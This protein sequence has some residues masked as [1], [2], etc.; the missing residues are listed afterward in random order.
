MLGGNP[1]YRR[2]QL[3]TEGRLETFDELGHFV[4]ARPGFWMAFEEG[5]SLLDG[6]RDEV[7]LLF[8]CIASVG[9]SRY[10]MSLDGPQYVPQLLGIWSVAPPSGSLS[11]SGSPATSMK[12]MSLWTSSSVTN[13]SSRPPR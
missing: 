5:A 1:M 11:F 4:E 12:Y 13:G 7:E 8:G 3:E 9:I 2:Q 10:E 6:A